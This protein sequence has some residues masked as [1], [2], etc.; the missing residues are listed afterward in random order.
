MLHT[1][2]SNSYEVLREAL[3]INVHSDSAGKT[4]A[5]SLFKPTE[6]VV[7]T[8]AVADALRRF[9]ADRD[10]ICAGVAFKSIGSW[11]IKFG[12]PLIGMGEA[13]SELEFLIWRILTNPEFAARF[14]RLAFYLKE[15]TATERYSFA[16][17]VA[18]VFSRY[19]TYRLDWVLQWMGVKAE[20]DFP[21]DERTVREKAALEAHPDYG[22]QKALW[23]ELRRSLSE[24]HAAEDLRN[25]AR[26]EDKMI[27]A[28]EA[29]C[30][31]T[32]HIFMPFALPPLIL[33]MLKKMAEG[34]LA[35][36]ADVY[37]YLLNPSQ[38]YWYESVPRGAGDW[39]TE[40]ESE[41]VLS[42][43][44]RNA[45]STRAVIERV[46]AFLNT[47]SAVPLIGV[48]P[49]DAPED[50]TTFS[51]VTTTG[52]FDP[53]VER[54]QELRLATE[55]DTESYF[56]EPG[57]TTLLRCLQSAFLTLDE[58]AAHGADLTDGSVVVCAAPGRLREVENLVDWMQAVLAS[59]DVR[60]EDIL[61][62]TP[63]IDAEAGVIEAVMSAQ[64]AQRR[65]PW[66]VLS[67]ASGAEALAVASWEKL[68]KFLFSRAD[69]AAFES[70]LELPLVL[71]RWSM[72]ASDLA[73]IHTWLA[74]GGYRFGLSD[75]HVAALA[76]KNP[77][78]DTD[79][80]GTLMKA[81]ERLTLAFFYDDA[82]PVVF[83]DL[84]AADG[85]GWQDGVVENAALFE[86]FA[87][88][89]EAL[90]EK[91]RTL[92]AMGDAVRPDDIR[93]FLS[94]LASEFLDFSEVP[95]AK[96]AIEASLAAVTEALKR[97]LGRNAKV[98]P[99]V[100]AKSAC[101][102]VAETASHRTPSGVTFAGMAAFRGLPF[103][104]VAV[105]GL[106]RG[107][108][109]P[110]LNRTEE[111]DLM[112]AGRENGVTARRGDRDSRLDNRNIFFD[113]LL[114]AREKFFVSYSEGYEKGQTMPPSVVVEDF[115]SFVATVTGDAEAAKTLTVKVPMTVMSRRNFEVREAGGRPWLSTD[116]VL[117]AAVNAAQKAGF[118]EQE[119]VFA[120]GATV[121]L[122]NE[123]TVG[124]DAVVKYFNDPDRFV[125][126]RA[127][128]AVEEETVDDATVGEGLSAAA[129]SL[130]K[131]IR[132]RRTAEMALTGV[133]KSVVT[134]AAAKDPVNG[135]PGI[136]ETVLIPE[137]DRVYEAAALFEAWEPAGER[138]A[139]AVPVTGLARVK[140]IRFP[141][142]RLYRADDAEVPFA[143]FMTF[144]DAE[145]RRLRLMQCL[146]NALFPEERL[147]MRF[148]AADDKRENLVSEASAWTAEDAQAA[149]TCLL[150]L[151]DALAAAADVVPSPADH[152]TGELRS[153]GRL[154]WRGE[155]A[156]A[157]SEAADGFQTALKDF[158]TLADPDD[159]PGKTEAKRA[160]AL[161]ALLG[162]AEV[163]LARVTNQSMNKGSV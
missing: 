141:V 4:D 52:A 27:K 104:A 105:L 19:A 40:G 59:G 54:L 3:L 57:N 55:Q 132:L 24:E 71:K 160:A 139:A 7:P 98:A 66:T 144:S 63:D 31:E 44:R 162:T 128:V 36:E 82:V 96:M 111:F 49:E 133:P 15:K 13:G 53:V 50:E 99:D 140:E 25:L 153:S 29:N 95:Q 74:A 130:T 137:I 112:A 81:L 119:P 125:L 46:Y 124:A 34:E 143:A 122:A 94:S 56:V 134:A 92:A 163:L 1:V 156:V 114:A 116:T 100:F 80:D 64:P 32:V 8:E 68:V 23:Q 69:A 39:K 37:L 88:L 149:Q 123:T 67:P 12:R 102:H 48:E 113:L 2:F 117:L 135:A 91:R 154:L 79:T 22:W 70:W 62:V 155:T 75:A 118:S 86:R 35:D 148:V 51:S 152:M 121:L 89:A 131:S 136:R 10:G 147:V 120:R 17:H 146:R 78:E 42:Y 30:G 129:D 106:D 41:T 97:T 14:E 47:E 150:S 73:V 33:P 93:P 110:G 20:T 161:Q 87:V 138:P 58:G 5:V 43:L 107:S 145:R 28:G 26:I 38:E 115:L 126:R 18:A 101:A 65:I 157:Q 45:A 83:G 21:M 84:T 6:V 9:F 85:A 127:G 90:E 11:F 76:A 61:V 151:F 77:E 60:P 158:L 16:M 72:T 108:A 103:K 142:M 159:A 109:F